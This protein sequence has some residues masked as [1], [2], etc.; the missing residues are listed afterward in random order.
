PVNMMNVNIKAWKKLPKSIQVKVLEIA[1]EMEDEM[2][3]LAGDMDRKSRATLKEKGMII[4]PVSKKF[5]SELEKIGSELRATWAKKAGKDAQ[6]ILKEYD[7]ITG[8]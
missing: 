4:N 7:K 6:N 2:W 5:R 1:A 8:R 3:N